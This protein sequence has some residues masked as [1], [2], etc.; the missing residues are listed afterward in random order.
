[1]KYF[2]DTEFIEGPQRDKRFLGF[3]ARKNPPTIDLISIGVVSEDGRSYY[4]I[5]NEFNLNEAWDRYQLENG[6]KVYWLRDNVLKPL[7]EDLLDRANL[8][9]PNRDHW[10]FSK[11]NMKSALTLY[12]DS[13]EDITT[14]IKQ[15]T[16]VEFIYPDGV[17]SPDTSNIEFYAYY[18]DYDWVV[19]CWLFGRMLDLP[20]PFPMYCRDLKQMYDDKSIKFKTAGG[21]LKDHTLY[22]GQ[23]NEHN[24][25]ADAKWNKRLFDFLSNLK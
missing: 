22:P 11:S 23:T 13:R 14:S 3:K 1:M 15:F 8:S 19:F 5:S 10:N 16:G 4:G 9:G 25:L 6:T 18:A 21:S 2:F 12:G 20:K 24:A 7:F 17:G